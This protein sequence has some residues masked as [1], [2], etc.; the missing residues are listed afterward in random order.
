MEGK[1][2]K[3]AI[4]RVQAKSTGM[5]PNSKSKQSWGANL[6]IYKHW[7]KCGT[8]IIGC[9][10]QLHF[11]TPMLTLTSILSGNTNWRGRLWRQLVEDVK[12]CFLSQTKLSSNF[13]MCSLIEF[14][15]PLYSVRAKLDMKLKS[16]QQTHFSD[17]IGSRKIFYSA[18]SWNVIATDI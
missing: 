10:R 18:L 17:F 5:P 12:S 4:T 11:F 8:N 14:K 7:A 16:D 2:G 3:N 13:W 9:N 1:L 6:S 15:L